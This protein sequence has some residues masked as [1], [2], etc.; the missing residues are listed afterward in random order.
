MTARGVPLPDTAMNRHPTES[1][2]LRLYRSSPQVGW[3]GLCASAYHVPRELVSNQSPASSHLA[4]ILYRGGPVHV[5]RRQD[6]G[7]W[8][9]GDVSQGDLVVKWGPYPAY[10]ARGWSL[11]PSPTQLLNLCLSREFLSQVAQEV[12]GVDLAR[13]DLVDQVGL[14]DPLLSQ[15]AFALWHE[16]DHPA[17]AGDLFAQ[18]AAHLLAV[19]LLRRYSGNPARLKMVPP[20]AQGLTERQVQRVVEFIEEH[21]SEPLSQEALAQQVGFSPYHFTRVF[22]QALGASPHQFVLRQRLERA[23]QLLEQTDLPLAQVAVACGFAHQSHMTQV[24]TQR[25]GCTPHAYRRRGI[26]GA[27]F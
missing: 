6:Q 7:P 12:W 10:E 14:Q 26:S 19:Y 21:L 22:R 23:R 17:P 15:I 4:L 11:S 16:L 18:S 24:F 27:P 9:G 5:E 13:L 8:R 20:P 2:S 1:T 3:E 25:L